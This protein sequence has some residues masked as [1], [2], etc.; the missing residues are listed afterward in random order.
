VPVV[1]DRSCRR[2]RLVKIKERNYISKVGTAELVLIEIYLT[3]NQPRQPQIALPL[4]KFSGTKFVYFI[5][6]MLLWGTW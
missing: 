4:F 6:P 3:L 1:I 2:R 5:L